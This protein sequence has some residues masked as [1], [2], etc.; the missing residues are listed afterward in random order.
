MVSI[1]GSRPEVSL[2]VAATT[3]H[4]Q[5]GLTPMDFSTR[6]FDPADFLILCPDLAGRDRLVAAGQVSSSRCVLNLAPWSRRA[7]SLL[8]EAPFLAEIEIHGISTHAWAERTAVKLLEGSGMVDAIDPVTANMNDMSCFR[9][10]AWTHDVA[11]IPAVRWLVVPKPGH[12]D[13][14]EVFSGRRRPRSESPKVLLYR[15]TFW[16]AS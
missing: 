15:I 13:R 8:R 2:D 10:S 7:G 5:L 14:L 4:A 11:A 1:A 6:A 3:I 16:V 9:L 12:G